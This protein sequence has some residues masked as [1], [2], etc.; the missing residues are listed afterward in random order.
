MPTEVVGDTAYQLIYKDDPPLTDAQAEALAAEYAGLGLHYK[1]CTWKGSNCVIIKTSAD[2]YKKFCETEPAPWKSIQKRVGY[3]GYLIAKSNTY[4]PGTT[5]FS[6]DADW[7]AVVAFIEA[8][9]SPASPAAA[10]KP[11]PSVNG[12]PARTPT[13]DK[14]KWWQFWR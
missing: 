5:S 1:K 12:T 10:R 9:F 4:Q 7:N 11:Q 6:P 2:D 14:R 13:D 3:S 8:S